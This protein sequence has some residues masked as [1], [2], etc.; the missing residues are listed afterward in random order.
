L[1]YFAADRSGGIIHAAAF[2]VMC[3][4]LLPPALQADPTFWI[5]QGTQTV[6]RC[7]AMRYLMLMASTSEALGDCTPP[8][9]PLI[10][11]HHFHAAS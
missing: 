3:R 1:R 10:Y 7:F 9:L 6:F 8:P 2:I 5:R 4:L 11:F